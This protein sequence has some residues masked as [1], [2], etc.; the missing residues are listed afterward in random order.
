[1]EDLRASA[2]DVNQGLAMETGQGLR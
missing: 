1:V 2:D